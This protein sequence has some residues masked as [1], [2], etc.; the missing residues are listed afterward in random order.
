MGG[1]A[2]PPSPSHEPRQPTVTDADTIPCPFCHAEIGA[3]ARKCRHC[4]EWIAR[5]CRSCNTP[6]R[7]EWAARGIC[8]ECETR[9]R[10]APVLDQAT[11]ALT[12]H[13]SRSTAVILA[14]VLGGL[15]F[16]RFYTGRT[17]TGILYM[18][19][20][21]TG[22]PSVIGIVEGVR[23]AMMSDQEWEYRYLR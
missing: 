8:H 18:L 1:P 6:V 3:T 13:K 5:R 20:C 9:E 7:D 4:R 10:T 21:W 15:G 23:Y 22:I 11:R 14:L 16:H 17:G 19:F 12:S 2:R